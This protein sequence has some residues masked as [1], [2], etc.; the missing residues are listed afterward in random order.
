MIRLLIAGLLRCDGSDPLN[1]SHPDNAASEPTAR[2]TGKTVTILRLN[3]LHPPPRQQTYCTSEKNTSDR[4][5]R[6]RFPCRGFLTAG[7]K[8]PINRAPR[9]RCSSVGQSTRL[10]SA[11]SVVQVHPPPPSRPLKR[12]HLWRCTPRVCLRRPRGRLSIHFGVLPCTWV[13]LSVLAVPSRFARGCVAASEARGDVTVTGDGRHVK[14]CCPAR[15]AV[16]PKQAS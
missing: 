8:C 6:V 14:T 15:N 7:D 9:R 16:S 1:Q 13:L 12:T 11:E 2:T 5:D 3:M 4:P 10:I